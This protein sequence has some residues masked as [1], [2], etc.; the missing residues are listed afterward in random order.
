MTTP[1]T[2]TRR[3]RKPPL[4]APAEAPKRATGRP[5]KLS[6]E[7]TAAFCDIIRLGC[8]FED[9]CAHLDVHQ[10]TVRGWLERAATEGP[11]GKHRIFSVAY[12]KA[13]AGA[14]VGLTA[15]VRKK[16]A[17]WQACAW[18][19]ERRWPDRYGRTQR[20]E[21]GGIKDASPIPLGIQVYIPKEDE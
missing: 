17:N 9:A 18:I 20:L 7:F 1:S 2:K 3:A 4:T 21:L 8:Y 12:K 16:P 6:P 5:S 10:D 11:E 19:L 14:R 13:D 15:E